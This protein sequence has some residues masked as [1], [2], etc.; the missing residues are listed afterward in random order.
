MFILHR[1]AS[2]CVK[3]LIILFET[4][5][6]YLKNAHAQIFSLIFYSKL[7]FGVCVFAIMCSCRAKNIPISSAFCQSVCYSLPCLSP[8]SIFFSLYIYFSAL[9]SSWFSYSRLVFS[10]SKFLP[11]TKCT[12]IY[13]W[14][15]EPKRNTN[16]DCLSIK[17]N[18]T[19][20]KNETSVLNFC[21]VFILPSVLFIAE[22]DILS[23]AQC[24]T[25]DIKYLCAPRESSLMSI[26]LT[27]Y[28]KSWRCWWFN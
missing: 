21:A 22:Q 5:K 8:V 20:C 27:N 7:C 9:L 4:R 10:F 15:N 19:Q 1:S 13:K 11:A 6:I 23:Y 24:T 2:T 14:R 26:W 17:K 25:I 18:T 16:L 12:D 3:L 28:N